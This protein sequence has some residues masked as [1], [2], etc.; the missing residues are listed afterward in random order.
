MKSEILLTILIA[1]FFILS[2]FTPALAQNQAIVAEITDFKSVDPNGNEYAEMPYVAYPWD[3]VAYNVTLSNPPYETKT[4]HVE[5]NDSLN[6]LSENVTLNAGERVNKTITI[7]ANRLSE[8]NYTIHIVVS[9]GDAHLVLDQKFEIVLPHAEFSIE[10]TR[11]NNTGT[12]K[13]TTEGSKVVL[14]D[15]AI[16]GDEIVV[17]YMIKNPGK[18]RLGDDAN[19]PSVD[20]LFRVVT[21]EDEVI[22]Y[23]QNIEIEKGYT[24]LNKAYTPKHSGTYRIETGFIVGAGAI[25]NVVLDIDRSGSM[26]GEKIESAKTAAKI[27]VD[28]IGVGSRGAVVSYGSDVSVDCTLKPDKKLLKKTIDGLSACGATSMWDSVGVSVDIIKNEVGEN[29]I[30]VLTDGMTNDDQR[31]NTN[32]ATDYAKTNKIPVYTIGL[33]PYINEWNLKYVANETGGG[34]YYA[35]TTGELA[36]IY[37]ELGIMLTTTDQATFVVIAEVSVSPIPWWIWPLLALLIL[38]LFIFLRERYGHKFNFRRR[39]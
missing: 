4:Y 26:C 6:L 19:E 34:Y 27:F 18:Y 10:N 17:T 23:D 7:S 39:S 16:G 28:Q 11:T 24:T 13:K 3:K 2:T 33:G 25:P 9:S 21:P 1:L 22:N 31:Y 37:S 14:I 15:D 32:T 38:L 8:G 36:G 35:P 29:A 5:I 30:I 12:L 20:L